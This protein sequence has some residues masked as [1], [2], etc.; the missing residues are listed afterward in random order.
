VISASQCFAPQF[1][2]VPGH[3]PARLRAAIFEPD[4]QA[5]GVCVL[6]NGQTEFIEKYFEVIDELRGRGFAV[7]T[8]DWRGQGGSSRALPDSRKG[9]VEDFREYDRDL[10]TLMREIVAPLVARL[11]G[12]A[13]IGLAH[14]MGGH[15]LLRA[16][17][18]R[19]GA[20]SACVFSAP[21]IGISSRD[22]PRWLVPLASAVMNALGRSRDFIWGMDKRDP[23]NMDFSQQLVTSDRTRFART[24]ALLRANP[25]LM[26]AGATWG[27]LA[28]AY[29]SLDE[30]GAPDYAPAISTPVLICGAGHDRICVTA[31]AEAF[32]RRMKAARY[33]EIAE[34]EH[35]IL[36]ERDSIREMF[37]AAF[38]DFLA[39]KEPHRKQ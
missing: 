9:Y 10:E 23:A 8:M 32:A 24:Q 2:A 6:L 35:E 21:M 28:A 27:W 31:A 22:E 15:N 25:A 36:M 13:P 16:L 11:G 20:F 1:L 12:G 38:D 5:R 14:S 29:R 34:A 18:D 30:I 17:H 37:W 33:L 19:P 39:K 26:L 4:G 3:P 7:A